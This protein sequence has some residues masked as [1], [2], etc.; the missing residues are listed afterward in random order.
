MTM[1]PEAPLTATDFLARAQALAPELGA[2][3]EIE[4]ARR[5]PDDSSR[6]LRTTGVYRMG[7]SRAGAAP[8]CRRC[9]SSRSSSTVLWGRLR[10]LVRRDRLAHRLFA[11][12]LAGPVALEM[13]Q[14]GR[15]TTGMLFPVAGPSACPAATGCPAVDLRHGVHPLRLGDL[16]RLHLP[17]RAAGPEP[18]R[19]RPARLAA[20]HVRAPTSA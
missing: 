10:R 12:Y 4:R 16:R 17:G 8:N 20:V 3:R 18:R 15:I 11:P 7:F 2:V 14:P 1:A 6:R 19:P 5:L 13:P 9:T